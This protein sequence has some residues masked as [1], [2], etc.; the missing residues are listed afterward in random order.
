[1]IEIGHKNA[2]IIVFLQEYLSKTDGDTNATF[3]VYVV[4]V[5]P[6]KHAFPPICLPLFP[7]FPHYMSNKSFFLGFVKKKMGVF[8]DFYGSERAEY[9][10]PKER[11]LI[12]EDNRWDSLFAP[13]AVGGCP[14]IDFV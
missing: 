8:S 6:P 14:V 11:G 9:D 2:G 13:V 12:G 7:T 10:F 5:S 1:M 4:F 3:W